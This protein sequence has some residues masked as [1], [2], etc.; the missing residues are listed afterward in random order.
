MSGLNIKSPNWNGWTKSSIGSL[1]SGF[2][3]SGVSSLSSIAGDFSDIKNGS[4]GKLVKAY[5][6]KVEKNNVKPKK[7][8]VKK[9]DN[10]K[11]ANKIL[12]EKA[13]KKILKKEKEVTSDAASL[14]EAEKKLSSNG[15]LSVFKK[16]YN[17]DSKGNYGYHYDMDRIYRAV[18]G[19]TKSYNK[20]IKSTDKL[21]LSSIDNNIS[22][23]INTTRKNVSSL[24]EIGI[25]V[26]SDSNL[27]IDKAKF[28]KSDVS[29]IKSLFQ[30]KGSYASKI[31]KESD[32]IK[33]SFTFDKHSYNNK[34]KYNYNNYNDL[35]SSII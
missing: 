2:H 14:K 34:G 25:S 27:N 9:D 13:D 10:T 4:Y 1:F 23:M 7:T 19:F 3:T 22:R 15:N 30:N 29:K 16:S 26:G 20:L 11:N 28:L 17:K 35:F 24:E 31:A 12:K 5:Y 8:K 18:E 32:K 6:D 33:S 21:N